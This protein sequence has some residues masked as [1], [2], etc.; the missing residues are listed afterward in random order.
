MM[1]LPLLWVVRGLVALLQSNAKPEL[2]RRRCTRRGSNLYVGRIPHLPTAPASD[3]VL[4]S[5][6]ANLKSP[7]RRKTRSWPAERMTTKGSK[8]CHTVNLLTLRRSGHI[9]VALSSAG[10]PLL[11]SR[12][13]VPYYC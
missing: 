7:S 5:R 9:L 4:H 3:R 1:R 12:R 8:S 10:G 13:Q 2:P 11:T 6:R